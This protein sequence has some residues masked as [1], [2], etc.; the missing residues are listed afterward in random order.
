MKNSSNT[1]HPNSDL[2]V[3]K[4]SELKLD[5]KVGG[6]KLKK[7]ESLHVLDSHLATPIIEKPEEKPNFQPPV[8]IEQ[9]SMNSMNKL[10]YG[11][12]DS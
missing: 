6:E 5:N 8:H 9:Q 12:N 10:E 7:D 11:L 3:S 1:S 2:N 4:T